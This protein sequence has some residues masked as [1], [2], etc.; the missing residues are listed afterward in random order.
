[1]EVN[2]EDAELEE[3]WKWQMHERR[4]REYAEGNN[5]FI[6]QGERGEKIVVNSKARRYNW[7]RKTRRKK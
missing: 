2:T 1:V 5:P 7:T 6:R 3:L 4:V